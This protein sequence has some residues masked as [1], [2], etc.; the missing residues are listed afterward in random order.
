MLRNK[1]ARLRAG[2]EQV[3][4]ASMSLVANLMGNP[5]T[6]KMEKVAQGLMQT[7]LS[8]NQVRPREQW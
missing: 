8:A 2:L 4:V 5:C 1:E 7:M 3:P 6:L